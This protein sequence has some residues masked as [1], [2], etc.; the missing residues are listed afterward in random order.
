M[1]PV[2]TDGSRV[3]ERG[4]FQSWARRACEPEGKTHPGGWGPPHPGAAADCEPLSNIYTAV[5]KKGPLVLTAEGQP[6]R[7]EGGRT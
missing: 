3:T 1:S 4:Q 7:M 5:D 6:V 2:S